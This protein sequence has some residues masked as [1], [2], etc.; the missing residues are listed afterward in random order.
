MKRPISIARKYALA[1]PEASAGSSPTTLARKD[2][3][4]AVRLHSTA[5]TTMTMTHSTQKARG[6]GRR[7]RL[8]PRW[9]GSCGAAGRGT[10]ALI[11]LTATQTIP[12]RTKAR[13]QPS[14]LSLPRPISSGGRMVAALATTLASVRAVAR[15]APC[16]S[17]SVAWMLASR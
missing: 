16:R 9:A 3:P 12:A 14:P 15:R 10:R 11:T 17:D 13:P 4:Q 7:V 2:V 5:T 8:P 1:S 6:S